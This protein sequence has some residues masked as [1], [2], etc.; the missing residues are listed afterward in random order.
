MAAALYFAMGPAAWWLAA[1]W[2]HKVPAVAGLVALGA[3]VY[4]GLL[5][6]LGMRWRDFA[7]QEPS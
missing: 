4:L 1:P 3:L 2:Q 6:A 7:R 5:F